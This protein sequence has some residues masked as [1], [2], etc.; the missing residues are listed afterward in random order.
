M[1][2]VVSRT[3]FNKHVF[4]VLDA[5]GKPSS[6][7]MDG[8]LKWLGSY[9][10]CFAVEAKINVS[11]EVTSPF[12]G[13]YCSADFSLGQLQKVQCSAISIRTEL[14]K[15]KKENSKATALFIKSRQ[16]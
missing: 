8:S 16:N 3:S 13:R 12:T 4:P 14:S 10:E 15:S 9:D 1:Q 5:M 2:Y 7:L 6:G 11:G